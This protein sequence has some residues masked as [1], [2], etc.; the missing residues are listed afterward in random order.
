MNREVHVRFWESPEVKVLRA[1]RQSET[2]QH[3]GDGGRFRRKRPWRPDSKVALLPEQGGA[4]RPRAARPR[5]HFQ[6]D[7]FQNHQRSI[8]PQ[9]YGWQS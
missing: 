1:T 5:Q 9:S 8:T 6:H 4:G 7:A 3:V 2:P